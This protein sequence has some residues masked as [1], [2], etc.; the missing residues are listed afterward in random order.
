[1]R[2]LWVSAA[3]LAGMVLLLWGN[4]LYLTQLLDPMEEDLTKATSAA[5]QG[6]I[7]RAAQLTRDLQ[8][9]W[10][11]CAPYLRLVQCHTTVDEVATLLA[12]AE[13][14]L[15]G[16]DTAAYAAA[17]ARIQGILAQV[18]EMERVTGENLF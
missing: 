14:Y 17:N 5:Q 7:P 10:Q 18:E 16:G 9:K 11:G 4:R 1:M 6:E 3:I 13:A 2:Q 12:E 15:T 8:A